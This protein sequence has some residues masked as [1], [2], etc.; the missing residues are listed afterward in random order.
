ML[1]LVVDFLKMMT[2]QIGGQ[3]SQ[4][5]VVCT[6]YADGWELYFIAYATCDRRYC[7]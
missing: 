4:C 2:H 6:L 1:H 3:S 5:C 7:F